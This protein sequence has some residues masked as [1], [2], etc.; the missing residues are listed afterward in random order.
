MVVAEQCDVDREWNSCASWHRLQPSRHEQVL[1]SATCV[2]G[3]ACDLHLL[4][5][6][7][8]SCLLAC[9][10][11]ESNEAHAQVANDLLALTEKSECFQARWLP[12]MIVSGTGLRPNEHLWTAV[13]FSVLHAQYIVGCFRCVLIAVPTGFS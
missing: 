4:C 11:Q 10:R 3:F 9:D 1:M 7:C 13:Q 2:Q 12:Q 8:S 5:M 6:H